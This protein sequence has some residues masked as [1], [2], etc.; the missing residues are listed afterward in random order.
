[1][2]KVLLVLKYISNS[3]VEASDYTRG[4]TLIEVIGSA[5]TALFIL[6]IIVQFILFETDASL[7]RMTAVMAMLAMAPPIWKFIKDKGY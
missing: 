5:G 3:Y 4:N 2:N 1:M 6:S 7:L